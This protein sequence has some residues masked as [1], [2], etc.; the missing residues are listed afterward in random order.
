MVLAELIS[1]F[2]FDDLDSWKN[3]GWVLFLVVSRGY[4]SGSDA[5]LVVD[6]HYGFQGGIRARAW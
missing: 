4:G 1:D 5:F 3:S 6:W 2:V